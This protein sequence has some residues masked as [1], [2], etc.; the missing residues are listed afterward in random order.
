[1]QQMGHGTMLDADGRPD[2]TPA[3]PTGTGDDGP[4]GAPRVGAARG[5]ATGSAT[6]IAGTSVAPDWR[7]ATG[8]AT[9]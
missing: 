1:M 4:L 5:H 6:R 9:P 7:D 8:R 3:P 2:E